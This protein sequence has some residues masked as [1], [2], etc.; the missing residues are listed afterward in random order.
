MTQLSEDLYN[1]L[2]D[3]REKKLTEIDCL[4]VAG[5]TLENAVPLLEELA[6]KGKISLSH[7]YLHY[8]ITVN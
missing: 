4:N 1:Y 5:I 3:N 6:A 7:A 8:D 2:L